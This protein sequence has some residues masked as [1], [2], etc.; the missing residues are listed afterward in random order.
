[1]RSPLP[2]G[3][4]TMTNSWRFNMLGG[5]A[6]HLVGLAITYACSDFLITPA[7]GTLD[8]NALSTRAGVEGSLIAAY[9]SLDCNNATNGNWGC[10]ASN[11]PFGSITSDDAYKGSE[12]S[13]QPQATSLELY[14]WTS[15]QSQDYLDRKW[16]SMYEGVVRA[17]ATIRLL[18]KVSTLRPG[19]ITKADS[20]AIRGEALFLRAHYPFELWRMWGNVPYYYE[21]DQDYRK[22]NDTDPVRGADSVARKI[23]ADLD[24]A[25]ALLPVTPRF[26]E[27][28]RATRW[29]ARAYKGRVLASMHQ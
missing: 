1:M 8:V 25:I 18:E 9:R 11:W 2:K 13:D 19:A 17:N 24:A 21:T 15:D 5:T 27:T 28:G 22:A 23:L 26:G 16:A 29:T 14:A 12:A 3:L 10:A 7:Q 4:K 6:C 20:M